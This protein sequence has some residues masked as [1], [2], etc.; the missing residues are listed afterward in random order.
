MALGTRNMLK[1][2]YNKQICALV[3][4]WN[5]NKNLKVNTKDQYMLPDL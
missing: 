2:K 3:I 4:Y 5:N 1:Q